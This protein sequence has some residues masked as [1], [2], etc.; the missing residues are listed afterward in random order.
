MNKIKLLKEPGYIYD[1][2]FIFYLKFNMQ[3]F[4]EK[5]PNDNEKEKNIA[6]FE[7]ITNQ[8]SDIPDDLFVFFHANEADRAFLPRFYFYQYMRNQ[9]NAIINSSQFL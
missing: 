9:M 7:D 5:L 4:I 2:F 6:F 8:F 3:V 1:L